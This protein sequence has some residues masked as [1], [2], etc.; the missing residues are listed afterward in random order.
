[1]A[2]YECLL[3]GKVLHHRSTPEDNAEAL[4]LLDRAVALDPDYAH[5]HAWRACVLGQ[6]YVHG[7]CDDRDADLGPRARRARDAP[8]A[9]TTTTATCTASWRPRA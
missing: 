1:M 5:A 8:R 4:R 2:A 7:W 3:A 9:S 6:A